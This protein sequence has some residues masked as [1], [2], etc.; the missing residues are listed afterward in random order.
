MRLDHLA[1]RVNDRKATSFFICEAF[2]YKIQEEFEILFDDESKA[3]C[4]A[5]EPKELRH[6]QSIRPMIVNSGFGPLSYEYHSQPEIF[7]S[8]GS[9]GSIVDKWV[10]KYGNGIHH[11]AYQ[12]E[13]VE[14]K[15]NEWIE[16]GLAEFTTSKPIS[17]SNDLVQCF[18][19]FTV[20]F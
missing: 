20:N 12:V 11:L 6:S 15:M 18:T 17:N 8:E 3:L 7:V 14:A 5:L 10:L 2:N 1:Y 16:K 19:K 4:Y 13:D 9:F